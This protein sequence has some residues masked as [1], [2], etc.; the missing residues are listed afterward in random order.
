MSESKTLAEELEQKYKETLAELIKQKEEAKN[1][2]RIIQLIANPPAG[3]IFALASDGTVWERDLDPRP[4]SGM[5]TKLYR[6]RK[7]KGPFDPE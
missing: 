7:V 5:P 1:R 4:Q 2:P 3:S 6:W